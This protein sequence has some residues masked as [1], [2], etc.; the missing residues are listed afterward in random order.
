M[1]DTSGTDSSLP[2]EPSLPARLP[3]PLSDPLRVYRRL[4]FLFVLPSLWASL[5]ISLLMPTLHTRTVPE[6]VSSAAFATS[7][8][9][10]LC[11][12]RILPRR[13]TNAFYL[14]SFRN[15]ARTGALRTAAQQA[16]GP[17][18]R[19]SGIRDPRRRWPWLIRHLSY[20]LFL[21]RY[22]QPKYMNLEAGPDWKARLWRSLGDARCA[23]IDVTDLTT[24]VCEEINLAIRC[25]GLHRVL[26]L[27]D[28]SRTP[29]E[30]RQGVLTA[31]GSPDVPSA[32][33][34]VAVWADTKTDRATFR[35]QVQ[36]FTDG[37][38]E[39]PP[40]L[41]PV[42]FPDTSSSSNPAGNELRAESWWA[43]LLATLIG[44][45]LVAGMAWTERQ[46]P[47]VG[48]LWFLPGFI[49]DALAL[50]LLLQYV[51]VCGTL[52]QQVRVGTT[53]LVGIVLAGLPVLSDIFFPIE[54]V[55][56]VTRRVQSSNNL[57][58]IGLALWDYEDSLGRP[59]PLAV[60]RPDGTPLLSWR[61][62][63]LPYLEQQTLFREFKLDEPWDGLH[64]IRLLDRIPSVY[65]SP[66]PPPA[67][68]PTATPYQMLIGPGTL[69]EGW[70][71]VGQR[72][73]LE[74]P[75]WPTTTQVA[76]FDPPFRLKDLRERGGVIL[77]V[78][79]AEG[80]P[81]TKPADLNYSPPAARDAPDDL[82]R[83]LGPTR[84]GF[85][86]SAQKS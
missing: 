1:S 13:A 40:G 46:T 50:L 78:E 86:V 18:F 3:K 80:V 51:V 41:N 33:V 47:Q 34:K 39:D 14:R 8:T 2:E 4:L 55:R 75:V 37:L 76:M 7:F 12:S 21:I 23:L 56:N 85:C 61:V 6:T 60:C 43:F 15:D 48:L 16:L 24:F 32:R 45:G 10:L 5:I 30:W 83:Q 79:A 11:V 59:P 44:S 82:V 38:P 68:S 63:L 77:A 71:P 58:Q 66:Y 26:F 27:V 29:E 67:G 19:L 62:L 84:F 35:D 57:K 81:W 9:L 20:I 72:P 49:Y 65:R 17:D 25:L 28:T 53:F 52:R 64:N 74:F 31:L 54:G 36:A 69:W 70:N 73:R 22:A 42:A